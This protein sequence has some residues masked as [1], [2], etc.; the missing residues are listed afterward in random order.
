MAK[1]VSF[2]LDDNKIY[3]TYSVSEYDRGIS[4]HSVIFLRYCNKISDYEWF[5]L[6]EQLNQFKIKEMIV[7]KESVSNTRLH[8]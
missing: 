7:H 5:S 1:V 8:T 4:I 2:N 6:F 3:D